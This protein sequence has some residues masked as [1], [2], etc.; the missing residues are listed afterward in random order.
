MIKNIIFDIG[1][2]LLQFDRD[3]LLSH[4]VS[5]KEDKSTLWQALFTDWEKQDDDSIP[6]EEFKIKVCN[7]LPNHLKLPALNLLNTWEDYMYETEGIYELVKFLK[8][9]GFKLYVLS[10]MTKHFIEN[11]EKFRILKLFDGIVYS[12]PLKM[13][14]PNPNFYTYLLEKYS[15]IPQECVFIDDKKD[16]LAAAARLSIKTFLFNK[17]VSEL[18]DYLLSL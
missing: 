1:N 10:N 11:Q 18:K 6:V 17:N 8:E 3:Y 9:K 14:K 13:M 7:S 5:T 4:F 16:N 15:L 12:A 2:V